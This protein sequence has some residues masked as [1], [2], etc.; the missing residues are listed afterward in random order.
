MEQSSSFGFHCR[1]AQV[2]AGKSR[3][4]ERG[5]RGLEFDVVDVEVVQVLRPGNDGQSARAVLQHGATAVLQLHDDELLERPDGGRV[6][7]NF[8]RYFDV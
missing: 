7:A 4:L 2:A 8:Y 5:R 1:G 6:S 3:S